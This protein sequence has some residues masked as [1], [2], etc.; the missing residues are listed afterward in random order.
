M[1]TNHQ[2]CPCGSEKEYQDCCQVGHLDHQAITTAEAL[3][4][5]RYSAYYLKKIDYLVETTHPQTR[6]DNLYMDILNWA[7]QTQWQNLQVISTRHGQ[8][9][10][11]V[12]FVEFKATYLINNHQRTIHEHSKFKKFGGKWYFFDGKHK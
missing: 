4:R 12:G 2:A 5:S 1:Q 11:K 9:E 6:S 8:K 3:M 7:N 10:D